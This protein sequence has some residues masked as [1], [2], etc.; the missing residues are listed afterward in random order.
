MEYLIYLKISI[1]ALHIICPSFLYYHHFF[2]TSFQPC[3]PF[4]TRACILSSF[5][6]LQ[7]SWT[8][9]IQD[10]YNITISLASNIGSALILIY[11]FI[12][13]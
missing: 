6:I 12:H 8:R 1:N 7:T 5:L 9:E 4:N 13:Q 3:H 11:F 2:F 10:K